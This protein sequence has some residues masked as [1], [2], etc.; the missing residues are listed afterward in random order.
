VPD[1]LTNGTASN[2][3]GVSRVVALAYVLAISIPP[4]GL[5]LGIA[6]CV[7]S[8]RRYLVHGIA[9]IVISIIA[10]VVWVLL[11]TGGGFTSTDTSY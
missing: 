5:I 4:L 8:G 7:R 10:T 9:V 3:Q 2:K 11:L 1:D 6:L